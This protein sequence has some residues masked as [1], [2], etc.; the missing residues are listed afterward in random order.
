MDY[1]GALALMDKRAQALL[2]GDDERQ[3]VFT[4]EHPPTI[5]I[6][7]NGTHD[8]VVTPQTKLDEMGFSVYNVDRGGD[9]TYHGPGQLVLYPVLHLAPW[10]NDVSRYVRMLEEVVIV[11]LATVD[12]KGYRTAGL[13]GVWV[14]EDKICAIGARVKKRKG[15]EFVTSHGLALNVNTDLSHFQ[16]IVPCGIVDRGVTSVAQILGADVAFGDWS[17][18]IQ[19]AFSSVFHASISSELADRSPVQGG[20]AS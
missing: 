15:G 8:H 20:E 1:Q 17:E 19:N 16:T 3:T 4:V 10:A 2:A 18:Y 7:R 5:T 14:G 13:P 9:V 6:G 12:V 11:A